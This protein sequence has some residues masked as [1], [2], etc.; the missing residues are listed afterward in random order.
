MESKLLLALGGDS[1][2]SVWVLPGASV[3]FFSWVWCPPNE[4]EPH[5]SALSGGA[6]VSAMLCGPH[7]QRPS[8]FAKEGPS[9]SPFVFLPPCSILHYSLG[10]LPTELG[11]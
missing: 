5:R 6:Q 4:G 3:V 8:P 1:V 7:S 11:F 9:E 10:S 2:P